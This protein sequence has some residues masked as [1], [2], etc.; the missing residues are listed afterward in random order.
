S[1]SG[2]PEG[3][4]ATFAHGIASGDPDRTS[5]V[6]WTRVSGI[7]GPVDVDW[8]V[9]SDSE[10]NDVVA[11][12]R[13]TASESRDHTVKVVVEDL[14]PGGSWFYRFSVGETMS[15]VGRT[16][17]LTDGHMDR[18]VIAVA[19]CSNYPFGYFNAY[20]AIAN[21]ADVDVVAHL[22]DYIY[23]YSEDGYGGSTGKRIGRVHE[24]RHEIVSLD[25]YRTRHAQYKS[26]EGSMAM[27]ARHPL[28]AIWDDHEAANNPWMEGAE[29]HQPDEGDW[30]DRRAAALQAYYEWMPVRDP[31]PGQPLER[32]W[33][34][35][36]FGDLASLMTLESRHTG[37]SEQIYWGDLSR[38]ES[39]DD[40]QAFYRD[41]IGADDR[42]YLSAELESFL[43]EAFAESVQANRRWRVIGNQSVMARVAMPRL[44]EPFFGELRGRLDE[45][46]QRTIDSRRRMGE[47]GVYGDLDA[48]GGY[49]VARERFY[50]VAKDAGASDLLVITGDSHSYWAN[51]LY[52]DEG[53]SMGVELGTTGITSPRGLLA[54]GPEGLERYDQLTAEA[55]REVVWT[56]GQYRGFIRLEIDH[57]GAQANFVTITDIESRDYE[58]RTVYTANIA[59]ED[60]ELSYI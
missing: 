52:D 23:E 55:N 7:E 44:D 22:G 42:N 13:Q 35:Y 15:A 46:G 41:V 36:K 54:L 14:A 10:F 17:T 43:A 4:A 59:S 20:D 48:W 24:P 53:Q 30:F 49:P 39:A 25:D 51:A 16:K 5:V 60:G 11:M 32:Y 37:R 8:L 45:S 56:D 26:D 28:I 31:G 18:L 34:H 29:N 2:T 3:S 6:L 57:D 58:T 27:H 21:D 38:F 47:L 50:Q 9:A 12:G 1:R 19:S 40:A 33:R